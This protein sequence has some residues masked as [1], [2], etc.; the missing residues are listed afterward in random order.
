MIDSLSIDDLPEDIVPWQRNLLTATIA[1][2]EYTA[3]LRTVEDWAI[4]DSL[5]SWKL[6]YQAIETNPAR[7][8]IDDV[9]LAGDFLGMVAH[10]QRLVADEARRRRLPRAVVNATLN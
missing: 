4:V 8:P 3:A 7:L 6:L 1:P 10:A 9:T 5:R 2:E